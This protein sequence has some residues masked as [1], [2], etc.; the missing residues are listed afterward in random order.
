VK[1]HCKHKGE[2]SQYLDDPA[3]IFCGLE[4]KH[5]RLSYCKRCEETQIKY[6]EDMIKLAKRHSR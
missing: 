2:Q 3:M 5:I 6:Y 4:K 1:D